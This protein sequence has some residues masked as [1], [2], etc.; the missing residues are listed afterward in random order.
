MQRRLII[1]RHADADPAGQDHE[2]P[3]SAR[4]QQEAPVVAARLSAVGW[5]PEH[6]LVSAARRAQETWDLLQAGL[7]RRV[8]PEV[9]RRLYLASPD[10]ARYLIEECPAPV[11]CLLTLGHNPG[12][13][14]LAQQ[15]TGA[16]LRLGTA[17]AALL[18]GQGET[19]EE[20]TAVVGSWKLEGLI[21]P[22]P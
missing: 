7:P 22:H 8:S 16:D 21:R 14:E 18:S 13:E 17:Y 12:L 5:V 2:R 10:E 6:A 4:G 19:W 1:M 11:R 15:L 9:T 3:L 20:A